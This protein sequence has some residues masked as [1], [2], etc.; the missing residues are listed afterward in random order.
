MAYEE[1]LTVAEALHDLIEEN[2]EPLG[3][4]FVGFGE[5]E[6]FPEYPVVVVQAGPLTRELHATHQFKLTF[7]CDLFIYHADWTVSHSIRTAD[8]MALSQAVRDLLH[9]DKGFGG[10]LIF[11]YVDAETP[12]RIA[13]DQGVMVVGTHIS[14]VGES[15]VRF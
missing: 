3:I 7:R 8:D 12:G 4:R 14:W 15:V 5:D 11:S 6:I 2:K 1:P 9:K 13:T 10:Q